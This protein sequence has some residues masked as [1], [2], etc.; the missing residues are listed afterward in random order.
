MAELQ[1]KAT[2]MADF[3][4]LRWLVQESQMTLNEDGEEDEDADGDP[5]ED[6]TEDEGT[7]TGTDQPEVPEKKPFE[8]LELVDC[9][10]FGWCRN[11]A[12]DCWCD[13][14]D[15]TVSKGWSEDIAE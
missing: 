13:L 5:E 12:N 4:P 8:N 11:A 15:S 14:A 10:S 9:T 3:D 6:D 7:D 1:T 2:S